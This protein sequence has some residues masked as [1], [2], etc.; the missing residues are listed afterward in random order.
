MPRTRSVREIEILVAL[1]REYCSTLAAYR[2]AKCEGRLSGDDDLR[3][4]M[5]LA[6]RDEKLAL[7]KS[8]SELDRRRALHSTNVFALP[9]S[10]RKATR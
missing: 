5:T 1:A 9:R 10:R 8:N 4:Q 6:R 7:L 3:E 2:G